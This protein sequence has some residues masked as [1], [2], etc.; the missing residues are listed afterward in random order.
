MYVIHSMQ[1]NKIYHT[2]KY[3][4]QSKIL[5]GTPEIIIV[6]M[7]PKLLKYNKTLDFS[8]GHSNTPL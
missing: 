6:V 7:K 8:K 2:I 3:W 4:P 1:N 5:K